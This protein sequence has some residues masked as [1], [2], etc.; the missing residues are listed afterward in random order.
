MTRINYTVLQILCDAGGVTYR[1][2]MDGLVYF[3]S[4][5]TGSTLALPV[6]GLTVDKVKAHTEKSNAKFFRGECHND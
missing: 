5:Q 6:A 4:N 3:N 2:V 1:G